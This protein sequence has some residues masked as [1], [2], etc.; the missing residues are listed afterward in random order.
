MSALDKLTPEKQAR[1][2]VLSEKQ[3]EGVD[4]PPEE[5]RELITLVQELRRTTSGPAKPKAKK[6]DQ[7]SFADL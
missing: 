7:V 1:F 6:V 2:T 4:L 5:L 3:K